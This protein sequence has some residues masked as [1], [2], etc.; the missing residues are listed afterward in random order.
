[1]SEDGGSIECSCFQG[2]G[3]GQI[4][5]CSR[6]GM[7]RPFISRI[8]PD[9]QLN[10]GFA[11]RYSFFKAPCLVS[12]ERLS[13]EQSL[14]GWR[15]GGSGGLPWMRPSPRCPRSPAG[16][17]EGAVGFLTDPAG[18]ERAASFSDCG[19]VVTEGRRG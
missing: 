5:G 3:I 17:R 16:Q 19:L 1:M 7:S 18:L 15:S 2:A 10:D 12:W 6:E 11:L 13:H 4:D 8:D 14:A 9:R